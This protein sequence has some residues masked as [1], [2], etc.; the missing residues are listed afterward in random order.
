[1]T[2]RRVIVLLVVC[3]LAYGCA[4]SSSVE[5]SVEERTQA[6]KLQR[7]QAMMQSDPR[8]LPNAKRKDL[9]LIHI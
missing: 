7:R 3:A 8:A 2:T 1:M 5:M 9:S 4:T 6:H